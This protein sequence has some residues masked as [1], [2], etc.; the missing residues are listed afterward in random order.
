MTFRLDEN[1]LIGDRYK[2]EVYFA[3]VMRAFN[4]RHQ[5]GNRQLMNLAY[6]YAE[7]KHMGM[8]RKSGEPYIK[9][10]LRAARSLAE[11]GF[12]SEVI[13]AALLHDVVEDCNT[14]LSEIEAEFG[15]HVASIVDAVTALSDRDFDGE[16]PSKE[17]R[18]RLSDARLQSL[19][20]HEAMYV[21]IADRIDNLNTISG[22]PEAK[23]IPKAE[24]TRDIILPIARETGAW[25]FVNV[26]EEI[27]FEIEHPEQHRELQDCYETL[28]S[29]NST[30]SNVTLKK[31]MDIFTT[32]TGINSELE[33]CRRLILDFWHS[34]RSLISIYRQIIAE[35]ENI[36]MDLQPLFCKQ[37]IPQYD[38]FLIVSDELGE[39]GAP[40]NVHDLFMRFFD[41][42]LSKKGLYF[43]DIRRTTHDDASYY[44]LADRMDNL[45]RFFI[46]TENEFQHYLYG[47]IL[48]ADKDLSI[49]CI[50]EIDPRETY[51]KKIK[52]F[53]RDGSAMYID[54]NATV[55]DF[56]FYVHTELGLHFQ[57]A[58]VNGTDTQLPPY[59]RLNSGDTVIIET[60]EEA[61][62]GFNWFKY[63]RTVRATHQLVQ[64]FNRLY[65]SGPSW[66]NT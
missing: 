32:E 7:A 37:N 1:R 58:K 11:W 62:P 14:P 41:L 12:E 17:Q 55:L 29:K 4:K 18:D 24:H 50:N 45:Y 33:P 60:S 19:M 40:V 56:A 65:S 51:N 35:A 66:V 3:D 49:S 10:P 59:T 47:N 52:V 23:R 39:D 16:S 27:C 54:E 63:I 53:R 61:K 57:Y 28:C 30:A 64:Y 13:A 22:V 44:L 34:R 21:K 6:K 25:F 38:L 42:E 43:V 15:S 46:R 26:L 20:N 31:F 48:E 36:H 8:L 9:H 5:M 2:K